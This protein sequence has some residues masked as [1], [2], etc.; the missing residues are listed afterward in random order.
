VRAA[1]Q[2]AEPSFP[3]ATAIAFPIPLPAPVTTV[4]F[5]AKLDSLFPIS[6]PFVQVHLIRFYHHISDLEMVGSAF[7]PMRY[8]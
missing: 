7:L 4:T 6:I 8:I 2:T 5:P 1:Q 3:N